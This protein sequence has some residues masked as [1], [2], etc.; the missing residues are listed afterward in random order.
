MECDDLKCI[1]ESLDVAVAVSS[2]V[3]VVDWWS[4]EVGFD[5][6]RGFLL[7]DTESTF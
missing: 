6:E 3:L 5:K 2:V 4:N 1:G 7:S